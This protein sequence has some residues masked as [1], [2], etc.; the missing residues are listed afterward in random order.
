MPPHH[1]GATAAAPEAASSCWPCCGSGHDHAVELAHELSRELTL[2]F[3]HT[4]YIVHGQYGIFADGDAID[5][6]AT[7][8]KKRAPFQ[9]PRNYNYEGAKT[10][11]IY[12]KLCQMSRN[13]TIETICEIGFNAGLSAILMLE[14]VKSASVWSFDL[15]DFKWAR[16]A[17][18]LV[19]QMY[20][21]RRFPG[22]IF[23]D[24][25][26]TI[27]ALVRQQPNFTCDAAF[28]DGAK[29]YNG[30]MAHIHTVRSVARAGVRV[31]LDEVTSFECVNGSIASDELHRQ[32]CAGLNPA[33]YPASLAHHHAVQQGRMRVLECD[34]PKGYKDKDGICLAELL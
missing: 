29:T 26:K 21:T 30:R 17:D 10:R 24:S 6:V 28:I 15:A 19:Q 9:R 25:T 22:V 18:K 16:T 20:G 7:T 32:R 1:A 23:G 8:G 2:D 4:K 12:S 34:W 14:S 13:E 27:K 33:Y 11:F 3:N 31:F 5:Y